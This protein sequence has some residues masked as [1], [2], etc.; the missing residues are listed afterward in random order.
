MLSD[1]LGSFDN[2]LCR[3]Y[4]GN[5]KLRPVLVSCIKE[6]GLNALSEKTRSEL[7]VRVATKVNSTFIVLSYTQL[8]SRLSVMDGV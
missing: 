2:Y 3:E 7:V 5:K 1:H 6:S 8:L 4:A